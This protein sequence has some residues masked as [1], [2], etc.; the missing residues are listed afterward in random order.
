MRSQLTALPK[1]V[2]RTIVAMYSYLDIFRLKLISKYVT[3]PVD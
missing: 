3:H 2:N 1:A